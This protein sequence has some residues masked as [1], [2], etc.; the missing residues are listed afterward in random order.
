MWLVLFNGILHF[1]F[2]DS[3][4]Q[5]KEHHVQKIYSQMLSFAVI[6]SELAG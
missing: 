3:E 1:L 2:L 4:S 5:S 6:V